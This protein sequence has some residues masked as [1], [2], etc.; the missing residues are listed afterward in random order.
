[1]VL[2]GGSGRIKGEQEGL[3]RPCKG[4]MEDESECHSKQLVSRMGYM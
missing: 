3:S 1:M 4:I 2:D